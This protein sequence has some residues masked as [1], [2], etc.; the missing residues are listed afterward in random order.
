[1]TKAT[2]F[3]YWRS[4]ASYRVRIALHLAGIEWQSVSVDLVAGEHRSSAHLHR[5]PQGLV[6]VLDI[7]GQRFTQSLAIIEYLDTTRGLRLL[8]QDPLER[9]RVQALAYSLA[10]DVHP[11]CNLSVVTQAT[12]GQ[13]PARTDWMRHFITP[14]LD[15]FDTLLGAFEQTP[16]CTGGALSLAD[17]CLVPQLY[18][19]DRWGVDYSHCRRIVAAATACAG[20]PAF[21]AAHPDRVRPQA[22]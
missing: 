17:L 20:H 3:D 12:G 13:E 15:A 22:G 14:G 9:A 6:P 1:M 21:D 18:N 11:V 10:V 2:L 8:P 7:D 4:T 5:N 16:Y 19:A